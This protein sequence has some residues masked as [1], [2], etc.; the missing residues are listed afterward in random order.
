[1]FFGDE[2]DSWLGLVSNLVH[3]ENFIV[4]DARWFNG[5]GALLGQ[6]DLL[7]DDVRRIMRG[8][9]GDEVFIILLE[10]PNGRIDHSDEPGIEYVLGNA[11]YVFTQGRA[12]YVS[13]RQPFTATQ[14]GIEFESMSTQRLREL[15]EKIK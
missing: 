15:L 4:M 5:K 14:D 11:N 6:G 2:P 3:E 8:L 1:M 10:G 7:F 12:H 9:E 13:D